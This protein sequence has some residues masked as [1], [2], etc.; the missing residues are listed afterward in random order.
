MTAEPGTFARELRK[1]QT[2]A[3]EDRRMKKDY[4]S[5]EG[6]SGWPRTSSAR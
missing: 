2:S 6:L 3:E 4:D 5:M 1:R